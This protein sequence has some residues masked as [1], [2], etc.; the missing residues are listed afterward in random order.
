MLWNPTMTSSE[1]LEMNDRQPA[2]V[3][4]KPNDME[5]LSSLNVKT[6]ES[7]VID[8]TAHQKS[9]SQ[10]WADDDIKAKANDIKKSVSDRMAVNY[11]E[12]EQ[13]KMEGVDS[14]EWQE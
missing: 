2:K 8:F 11:E 14:S 1:W 13:D 12:L 4:L 3:S 7:K 10:P 5:L 6:S 9:N